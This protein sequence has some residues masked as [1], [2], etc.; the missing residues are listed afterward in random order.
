MTST[1]VKVDSIR[2]WMLYI[3]RIIS[4]K[5]EMSNWEIFSGKNLESKYVLS[6]R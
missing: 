2:F 1:M 4:I 3:R 6:N 5:K